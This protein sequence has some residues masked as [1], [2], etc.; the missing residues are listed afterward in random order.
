MVPDSRIS[1]ARVDRLKISLYAGEVDM[2]LSL[3]RKFASQLDPGAVL[4]GIADQARWLAS[5][6]MSAV[7]LVQE[8][9]LEIAA[10]SGRLGRNLIGHRIPIEK[11][12]AGQA[13]P[14]TRGFYIDDIRNY[15]FHYSL[16]LE[17]FKGTSFLIVPLAG[18]RATFGVV[19]VASLTPGKFGK[20]DLI[21]L[22]LVMPGAAIAYENARKFSSSLKSAVFEER[23]RIYRKLEAVVSQTLFSISLI[24]DVLPRLFDLNPQE[25]RRRMEELRTISRNAVVE[26]RNLNIEDR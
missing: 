26:M 14:V 19:L 10:V 7:Y 6:E 11:S 2:L 8:G 15:S 21:L 12:L 4:Q 24:A 16:L 9:Q 5:A 20:D 18:E 13:L 22:D 3:Q 25:G 23:R 1:E 17:K